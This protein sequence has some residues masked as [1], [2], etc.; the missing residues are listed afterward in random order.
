MVAGDVI[1]SLHRFCIVIN[2]PTT[3]LIHLLHPFL[4]IPVSSHR[5]FWF[6]G[7]STPSIHLLH[8][9]SSSTSTC[10][11]SSF[12]LKQNR[13][14]NFIVPLYPSF[15]VYFFRFPSLI[16]FSFS[17]SFPFSHFRYRFR[18]R[19]VL[20]RK[21][22]RI[23]P[24]FKLK[25]ASTHS[26]SSSYTLYFFCLYPLFITHMDIP[27]HPYLHLSFVRSI[28]YAVFFIRCF[29]CAFFVLFFVRSFIGGG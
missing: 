16:S 19:G 1:D 3:S 18:F 11:I 24:R 5:I 20:P 8:R 15:H 12:K 4:V 28:F 9:H 17:G 7:F 23:V 29:F 10:T 25:F 27:S 22:P 13:T 26:R 6:F 2:I 21:I 14:L